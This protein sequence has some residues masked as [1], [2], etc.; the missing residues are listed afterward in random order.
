MF[1]VAESPTSWHQDLAFE[2]AIA[3]RAHVKPRDLGKVWVAPLDVILDHDRAIVLQPDVVFVSHERLAIVTD[4]VRG[5][6][7]LVVEVLSP[8]PRIGT[9]TERVECFAAHGVR[10]CWLVDQHDSHDRGADLRRRPHRSPGLGRSVAAGPLPRAARPAVPARGCDRLNARASQRTEPGAGHGSSGRGSLGAEPSSHGSSLRGSGALPVTC[11]S[12]TPN[13]SANSPGS[14][15][16][17]AP[18]SASSQVSDSRGGK[19][20]T[21]RGSTIRVSPAKRPRLS[22]HETCR[23]LRRA[24]VARLAGRW[25]PDDSR[26]DTGPA[27]QDWALFERCEDWRVGRSAWNRRKALCPAGRPACQASSHGSTAPPWRLEWVRDRETTP[28][29]NAASRVLKR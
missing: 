13:H 4:K 2:I 17:T 25:R 1:R 9:L 27:G 6:P 15:A 23:P 19:A 3:I 20:P 8:L 24:V 22:G 21:I 5:A 16:Q 18:V 14:R 26:S 7:D 28:R 10:E 11:L 12:A 29:G